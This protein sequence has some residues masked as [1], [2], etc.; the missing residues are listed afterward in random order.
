MPFASCT[1]TTYTK[2]APYAPHLVPVW[3]MVNMYMDIR[4]FMRESAHAS[5]LVYTWTSTL[6]YIHT[7]ICT[8]CEGIV[9]LEGDQETESDSDLE[10]GIQGFHGV[11]VAN[12]R[13]APRGA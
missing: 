9:M 13:R 6:T 2:P 1:L 11:R 4:V 3:T 7:Y 10:L 8:Q 5:I 12:E